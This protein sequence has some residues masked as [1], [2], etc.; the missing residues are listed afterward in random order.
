M[1]RVAVIV[2]IAPNRQGSLTADAT[3][4]TADG[5]RFGQEISQVGLSV[6]LV[7][8]V[9][10]LHALHTSCSSHGQGA[11]VRGKSENS[12]PETHGNPRRLRNQA[13]V[14]LA[15]RSCGRRSR[16]LRDGTAKENGRQWNDS[17]RTTDSRVCQ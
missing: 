2:R 14:S 3:H 6:R 17:S 13:V 16:G 15:H 4:T 12:K 9:G 8:D 7:N 1:R 10:R 11:D 5:D